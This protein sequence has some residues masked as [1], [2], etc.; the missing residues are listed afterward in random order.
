MPKFLIHYNGKGRVVDVP[1]NTS[2][3]DYGKMQENFANEAGRTD[4][5]W[6]YA[7]M[8]KLWPD[9]I[10]EGVLYQWELAGP[11]GAW[12][13]LIQLPCTFPGQLEAAAKSLRQSQDVVSMSITKIRKMI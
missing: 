6:K 13:N 9:Q 8:I 10:C 1:C 7:D 4:G 2:S 3:D 5:E 12:F 11:D